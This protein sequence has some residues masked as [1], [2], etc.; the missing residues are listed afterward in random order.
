M[1]AE[2]G[3]ERAGEHTRTGMSEAQLKDFAKKIKPKP[4]KA[5]VAAERARPAAPKIPRF[6][7]NPPVKRPNHLGRY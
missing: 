7:P 5:K 4:G 1:G 3:R 2:L 6:E